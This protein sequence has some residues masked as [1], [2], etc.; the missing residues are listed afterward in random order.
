MHPPG[1]ERHLTQIS[2]PSLPPPPPVTSSAAASP[3][4]THAGDRAAGGDDGQR[5]R[6]PAVLSGAGGRGGGGGRPRGA[7]PA[8][9]ERPRVQGLCPQALRRSRRQLDD[10]L[11][12]QVPEVVVRDL[13]N[14]F[15]GR[16]CVRV[17]RGCA[18][19]WPCVEFYFTMFRQRF[20]FFL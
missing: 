17:C 7:V 2:T 15:G 18:C 1:R 5:E 6:D 14:N 4:L 19:A 16:A 9:P 20:E 8:G 10:C 11:V 13:L 3:P 12:R